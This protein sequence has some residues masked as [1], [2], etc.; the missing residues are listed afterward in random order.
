MGKHRSKQ[1]ALYQ[2]EVFWAN[3]KIGAPDECW[4]WQR[5]AMPTG[6]GY[7]WD[8]ER[9]TY[10]HRH[11][12]KLTYGAIPDGLC[13]CHT[14]D[15]RICCNPAHLWVGTNADNMRDRDAK[16]RG[17]FQRLWAERKANAKPRPPRPQRPEGW[18]R[19]HM[20]ATDAMNIRQ[21]YARGVSVE[22]LADQYQKTTRYIGKIV[23]GEK[24]KNLP[25]E[26]SS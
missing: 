25:V 9:Y 5:R 6:Y 13:V 14:C 11:A 20:S 2:P 17:Y 1:T 23:R 18:K 8:G 12:Y 22:D 7:I 19:R 26:V 15:N 10:T 24:W 21:S 4:P 16:G 3:I